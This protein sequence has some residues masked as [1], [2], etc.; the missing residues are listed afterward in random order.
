MNTT[1][2]KTL[3][4]LTL[5][6]LALLPATPVHANCGQNPFGGGPCLPEVFLP[7]INLKLPDLII[8]KV[9]LSSAT[10]RMAYVL[11]R[12]IGDA[13]SKASWVIGENQT[14]HSFG[15]VG[16]LQPGQYQWTR[17]YLQEG[18]FRGCGLLSRFQADV[19]EDIPEWNE[20]NNGYALVDNSDC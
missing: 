18:T 6:A 13:P 5:G 15:F 10:D 19:F 11:V 17:V 2:L 7:T 9:V 16:S 3:A 14:G 20:A 4:A 8:R 12:N 1:N